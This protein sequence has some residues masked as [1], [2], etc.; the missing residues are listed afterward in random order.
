MNTEVGLRSTRLIGQVT[1]TDVGTFVGR[2]AER[3]IFKFLM[4]RREGQAALMGLQELQ[5]KDRDRLLPTQRPSDDMQLCQT[6]TRPLHKDGSQ[7]RS[8]HHVAVFQPFQP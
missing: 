4:R 2:C 3:I 6:I 1:H 8:L 7:D 5:K